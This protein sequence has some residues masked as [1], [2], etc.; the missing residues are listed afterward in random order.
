MIIDCRFHRSATIWEIKFD[1]TWHKLRSLGW[2][3]R[4]GHVTKHELGP[5]HLIP[6]SFGPTNRTIFS[7]ACHVPL[8]QLH[9]H[10][11]VLWAH[12]PYFS[13]HV[14]CLGLFSCKHPLGPQTLFLIPFCRAPAVP[15]TQVRFHASV[16]RPTNLIFHTNF[17][18]AY[19]V[20]STQLHSCASGLRPTNFIFHT[21]FSSACHTQLHSYA[22][23]LRPIN[24]IFHTNF[25]SEYHVPLTQLHFMQKSF[26]PT[27]LISHTNFSSACYVSS[28]QVRSHTSVHWTLIISSIVPF[29]FDLISSAGPN[30]SHYVHLVLL[31]PHSLNS[32]HTSLWTPLISFHSI[33][34][35]SSSLLNYVL[36]L[37]NI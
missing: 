18:S 17:S 14:P 4:F 19:H 7:N 5:C 36:L 35:V 13:Y 16:L 3:I 33:K 15:S 24:I 31:I 10:A 34:V 9:S 32:F 23:V 22:S 12:K 8:T 30:L 21:N 1:G 11:S 26:G 25:S 27:N 29:L 20:P 2:K 28:T 6:G 37:I